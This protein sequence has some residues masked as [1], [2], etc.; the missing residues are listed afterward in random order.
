MEFY[1]I[2]VLLKASF[3][4]LSNN[5]HGFHAYGAFDL[6]RETARKRKRPAFRRAQT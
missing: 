1:H 3:V 6:P 2:L 5:R 4:R